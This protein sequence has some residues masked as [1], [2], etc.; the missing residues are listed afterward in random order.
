LRVVNALA[1]D[2]RS[3]LMS[4][5]P[6]AAMLGRLT[7]VG[8][9]FNGKG[10]RS[11]RKNLDETSEVSRVVATCASEPIVCEPFDG[12]R[13][14]LGSDTGSRRR[15]D[16][17]WRTTRHVPHLQCTDGPFRADRPLGPRWAQARR[18]GFAPRRK[19]AGRHRE[20]DPPELQPTLNEYGISSPPREVRPS[21]FVLRP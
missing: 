11:L 6:A 19:T 5:R 2:C 7:E 1:S 13:R 10:W 9:I 20:H 17:A 12:N 21:D 3:S 15:G 4:A 18:R 14:P 16:V 8:H